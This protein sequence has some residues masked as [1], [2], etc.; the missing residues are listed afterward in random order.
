MRSKILLIIGLLCGGMFSSLQ[1]QKIGYANISLILNY[2]PESQTIEQQLS[3]YQKKLGEGLQTQEKVFQEKYAAYVEKAEAGNASEAELQPLQE[4]LQ[5]LN[6]DVRKAAAQAEQ[7]L[8]AKRQQLL[9]P[10]IQK[11]DNNIKALAQEESY[12]YILNA[13]DGSGNSIVIHGTE[14][15]DVTQKL[16]TRLGITIPSN[17]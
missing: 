4:E 14:G 2:M 5:K 17:N 16:M 3:T 9:E 15:D 13:L 10:V 7:E 1:A 11:L 12:D 6:E 8:I